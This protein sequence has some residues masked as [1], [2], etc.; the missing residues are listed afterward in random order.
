MNLF[1]ATILQEPW[2]LHFRVFLCF[3][4][5]CVTAGAQNE[6]QKTIDPGNYNQVRINGN[7]IFEIEIQTEMRKTIELVS[8]VDGEYGDHFQFDIELVKDVYTISL[9]Q[10]QLS[11]IEDDK[12]NAHKVVAA[13]MLLK[14]PQ[15]FIVDVVSDVG[16]LEIDGNFRTFRASLQTGFC[17]FRGLVDFLEVET[18]DGN[19]HLQ[20][21]DVSVNARSS[22]GD[23]SVSNAVRG[24]G[25]AT[26]KSINGDILVEALKE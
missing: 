2:S 10:S 18:R 20:T 9:W 12:R 23:V 26:L 25:F 19:I 14:L 21:M 3:L 5:L 6:L 17:R 16:N 22:K 15:D 7:Q 24:N 11:T 8:I 4:F 13:K 1:F